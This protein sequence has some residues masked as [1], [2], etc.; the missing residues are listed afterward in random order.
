MAVKIEKWV[1]AQK[2]HKLSDRHV[3]MARVMETK[4]LCKVQTA[5][6]RETHT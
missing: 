6:L 5:R 4:R 2:K 3:Q 1:V